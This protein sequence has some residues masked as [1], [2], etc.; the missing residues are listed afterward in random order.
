LPITL[1]A[2]HCRRF[3]RIF[4][5]CGSTG[6]GGRRRHFFFFFFFLIYCLCFL[7]TFRF[8]LMLFFLRRCHAAVAFSRSR[9]PARYACHTFHAT[10]QYLKHHA[11][12]PVTA[13]LI[14]P[15]P[16]HPP[17]AAPDAATHCRVA[18]YA[19]SVI[20]LAKSP[21][22]AFASDHA[23]CRPSLPS[24]SPNRFHTPPSSIVL[25]PPSSMSFH[26]ARRVC[27]IRNRRSVKKNIEGMPP[28]LPNTPPTW[29]VPSP[30]SGRRLTP[31]SA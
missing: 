4:S 23:E 31:S 16:G 2:A 15:P 29:V 20:T 1:T 7:R 13:L 26:R 14:T 12:P 17:A 24:S 8:L 25:G 18:Y 27:I 22:H 28:P 10:P 30:F 9:P 5:Q 3:S 11:P 19:V 21:R 6:E